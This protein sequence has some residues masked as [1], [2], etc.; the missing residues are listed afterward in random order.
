[1]SYKM[2]AGCVWP[3]CERCPLED[4]ETYGCFPGE[5]KQNAYYG[6]L[7]GSSRERR[8][9]TCLK[10]LGKFRPIRK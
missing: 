1:M 4:C 2:A 10:N 9:N 7:P 8:R 5:S 6:E 3:E